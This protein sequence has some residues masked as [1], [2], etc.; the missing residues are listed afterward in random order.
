MNSCR[1]CHVRDNPPP[2]GR[3]DAVYLCAMAD[4]ALGIEAD[5][6]ELHREKLALM[7]EAG[8]EQLSAGGKPRGATS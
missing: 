3:V 6:C 2:A 1:A 7:V 5:L 4:E 8:V